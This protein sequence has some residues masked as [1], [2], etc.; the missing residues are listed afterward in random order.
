MVPRVGQSPLPGIIELGCRVA[1]PILIQAQVRGR[2]AG[3][4]IL[5]RQPTA[6]LQTGAGIIR[7]TGPAG[8]MHQKGIL[9]F[10]SAS[11]SGLGTV[12]TRFPIPDVA[13]AGAHCPTRATRDRSR[14][15]RLV[16]GR[17]CQ[18]VSVSLAVCH[19]PCVATHVLDI[20]S[21]GDLVL[22]STSCV[23]VLPFLGFC[24]TRCFLIP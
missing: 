8:R 23:H 5:V 7:C 3:M 1:V 21:R 13:V 19:N 14:R 9:R 11:A 2:R 20:V 16:R 4:D 18:F 15:S 10:A 6:Y 17:Q 22:R 12:R 24:L